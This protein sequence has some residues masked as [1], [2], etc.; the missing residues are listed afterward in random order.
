[1]KVCLLILLFAA[2]FNCAMYAQHRSDSIKT[3]IINIHDVGELDSMSFNFCDTFSVELTGLY[4]NSD[5]LPSLLHDSTMVKKLLLK[6]GFSNIDWGSGNWENGP[7]FIYLKFTNGSCSCN[8]FK[9]YY[10][11]VKQK[12]GNYDLRITERIIC[13]SGKFMD[14]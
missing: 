10:Y 8:T 6:S 3:T 5:T 13:N 7:R 2:G 9:K 12:G 1:M 14:D 11:N 4:P